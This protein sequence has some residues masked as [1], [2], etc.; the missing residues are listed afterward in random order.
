VSASQP[1]ATLTKP[2]QYH[3]SGEGITVTYYPNGF[4]PIPTGPEG[5][6]CLFYQDASRKISFRRG[7]IREV[8][9][10]DIGT[11]LS[12]TIDKSTDLGDTTFS[13]VLSD[14][15]LPEQLGA[16]AAIEV[17]GI[18]T[19]HRSFLADIGQGQRE[20][21]S[22]TELAGEATVGVLPM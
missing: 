5:P 2:N 6:V 10:P 1:S 19:V 21:Y 15:A 7:E 20:T 14:V 4:G 12:V 17:V 9:V 13:V 8:P 22:L 3:L 16:S 18:T 11:V